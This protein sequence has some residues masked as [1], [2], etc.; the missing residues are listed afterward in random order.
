MSK[1]HRPS[2]YNLAPTPADYEDA[3]D[4]LPKRQTK[5]IAA[6]QSHDKLQ[7][8]PNV[9]DWERHPTLH[10]KWNVTLTC[11]H[12]TVASGTNTRPKMRAPCYQCPPKEV[13]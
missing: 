5:G 6:Q 11:G 13:A 10:R 1:P 12:K 8:E 7:G 9:V 2:L 4:V 3:F